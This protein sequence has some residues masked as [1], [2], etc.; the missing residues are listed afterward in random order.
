MMNRSYITKESNSENIF[1]N[2]DTQYKSI[3]M[4]KKSANL[5]KVR[6]SNYQNSV[7][8][9]H[10]DY[11]NATNWVNKNNNM[12]INYTQNSDMISPNHINS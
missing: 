10:T 2:T 4:R 9:I 7:K 8:N 6:Y 1:R 5:V 11:N 12:Q 3:N